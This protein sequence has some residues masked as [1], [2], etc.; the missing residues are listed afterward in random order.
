MA[1]NITLDTQ[2]FSVGPSSAARVQDWQ[3]TPAAPLQLNY[4]IGMPTPAA[5]D[6]ATVIKNYLESLNQTQHPNIKV[7]AVVFFI[8]SPNFLTLTGEIASAMPTGYAIVNRGDLEVTNTVTLQNLSLL[9]IGTYRA[10]IDFTVF[11][12]TNAPTPI[13]V[14]TVKYPVILNV[15]D[16]NSIIAEPDLLNYIFLRDGNLPNTQTA[17]ITTDS[18]WTLTTDKLVTVTGTGLTDLSTAT[19]TIVQGTGNKTI[20]VGLAAGINAVVGQRYLNTMAI[21]N[22]DGFSAAIDLVCNIFETETFIFEPPSLSFFAIQ[23]FQEA[24][25]LNFNVFGFGA[26]TLTAP[27]W[28]NLSAT[29][30][31][32]T[33][34]F[35]ATPFNAL[36]MAPGTYSGN[37]VL[38]DSNDPANT[39]NLPV[40]YI[41]AGTIYTTLDDGNIN[42][43][44]DIEYFNIYN[45]D[46]GPFPA[47]NNVVKLKLIITRFNL[48]S[49]LPETVSYDYFIPFNKNA[50]KLH[51]GEI[52]ERILKNITQPQ[53]VGITNLNTVFNTI[54]PVYKPASV[55]AE[56]EIINREEG[57]VKFTG[58]INNMQFVS[59]LKPE[60][61]KNNN[62][63]LSNSFSAKR[64]TPNSIEILNM[65]VSTPFYT[66]S[67]KK[68]DE[69][70]TI[71]STQARGTNNIFRYV[72]NFA[73][74]QPADLVTIKLTCGAD[75]YTKTFQVIPEGKH[76]NH[77]SFMNQFKT[78]ELMECTGDWQLNNE[79]KAETTLYYR[80]LVTVLEK[81]ETKKSVNIKMNTGFILRENQVIIDEMIRSKKAWFMFPDADY[82]ELIPLGKKLVGYDSD[83]ELYNY[84]LEFEINRKNDYENF[85]F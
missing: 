73:N 30:G 4:T 44:K 58:I 78:L 34:V 79:Y 54:L 71:I 15:I 49:F 45:V 32:D 19:Q 51:I 70:Y 20:T 5:T 50:S 28:L 59:G 14:D 74:Y 68:N 29:S 52:A 8:D 57:E 76:I 75:S 64:V 46:A 82:I 83:A 56:V 24:T 41:V 27:S 53:D 3:F 31:T 72:F 26:F 17:T 42:F 55:T 84:E 12:N 81:T 2:E 62:A 80:D 77:I 23:N 47:V 1:Y 67:I 85:T 69:D 22:D 43:T 10:I 33:G 66:I 61:F 37:I 65:L 63:I 16:G 6:I 39:Y 48:V 9:N 11:S 35:L 18:T 21:T 7:K 25:P 13:F 60:N 38:T 40:T 36:S